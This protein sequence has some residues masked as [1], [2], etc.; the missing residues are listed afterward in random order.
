MKINAPRRW[1]RFSLRTLLVVMTALCCWLGWE[2]SV[3]RGRKAVLEEIE[4]KPGF[5]ITTAADYAGR[6][7]P[8]KAIPDLAT[9]PLIRHWLGDQAIQ[10]IWSIRHYQGFSEEQ[11]ARL[12]KAFPEAEFRESYPEPCHPGCFPRGTLV[13]TPLGP[14]AI[15]TIVAGDDLV[16]FLPTGEQVIGRVQSVFVTDNRLWEVM[17]PGGKLLTTETQP[18]CL[19]D[20]STR[21][22]GELAPG[23]RVLRWQDGGLRSE[24]VVSVFSADRVEK[25]FNLVLGDSELFVAGGFLARSKPPPGAMVAD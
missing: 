1:F 22:A 11:L 14:R 2:S 16:A 20:Y 18:L 25:V 3:V 7:P 6:Y 5:S 13:E 23:D 24:E 17:T 12:T 9:V 19:A 10:E 8:G 21:P 15:E 4:G